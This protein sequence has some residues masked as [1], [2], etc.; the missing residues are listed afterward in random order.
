MHRRRNIQYERHSNQDDRSE[1]D[2][3]ESLKFERKKS[4]PYKSILT[5]IFMFIA[6]VVSS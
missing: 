4:F 2:S 1:I 5:A 6:G 3:A